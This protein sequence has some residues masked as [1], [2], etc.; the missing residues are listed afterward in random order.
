MKINLKLAKAKWIKNPDDPELEIKIRPFPMSQ[1]M[2]FPDSQEDIMEYSWK[3]FNYCVMDW[4]GIIDEND[5]P[6]PCNEK[7][8]KYIFDY[9]QDVMMWVSVEIRNCISDISAQKKT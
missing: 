8:K 6:L 7:N 2:W 1:G 3:R 9:V 5:K 4:K